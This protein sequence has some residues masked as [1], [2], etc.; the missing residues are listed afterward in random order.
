MATTLNTY[1]SLL[2]F[3]KINLKGGM[4]CLNILALILIALLL[5]SSYL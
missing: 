4:L 3:R 5:I 2:S 1:F